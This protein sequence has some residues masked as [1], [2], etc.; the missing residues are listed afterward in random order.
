MKK[1]L[2]PPLLLRLTV[3]SFLVA[4][5]GSKGEQTQPSL[6][7]I[8]ESVYASGTIKSKNQYQVFS[9][10]GGLIQKV[11][12][13]EGD[14]VKKGDPLFIIQNETPRLQAENARIA[15]DFAQTNSV[16]DRL[17]DLKT[18]I[19]TVRAK[20]T[21]DSILLDRQRGLWAQ[22]I[23]SKFELEQRELAFSTSQNNLQSAIFR[24]ND[25]KRQL[26]FAAAQSR[27]QLSI[28]SNMAQDYTI[29]SEVN[30]R[31]YSI[32]REQGE[33][34]NLQTPVALIGDASDFI[35]ELQVDENDIVRIKNGQQALLKFDSYPN[36][37]FEASITQINPLMNERTRTFTVEAVFTKKPPV[38]YP[39]LTTEANI[40]ILEKENALTIPRSYLVGDS[41]VILENKE[42]RR[43]ELGLKDYTKAEILS[44]LAAG[45]T[46]L[47]PK[48]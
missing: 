20:K 1:Q 15:A 43:V 3:L 21:S 7:K 8:T 11:L 45:E 26:E 5:C 28:S 30:G 6:E 10:V 29:R 40:V 32:A 17:S 9:T 18:T 12:V 22:Q 14:M 4:A 42:K 38:L 13:K 41:V 44:G 16:G 37:V 34:V 46:I 33:M 25:L 47:K 27:K 23:G 35:V 36:E 48:K 31:I 19:E 24:Y 39:N 2:L